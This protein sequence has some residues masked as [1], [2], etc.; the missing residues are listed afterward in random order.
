M[1]PQNNNNGQNGPMDPMVNGNQMPFNSPN[2]AYE[3]YNDNATKPAAPKK[4]QH[5]API[6][7]INTNGMVSGQK[8]VDEVWKKLGVSFGII[9]AA[10][11]VGVVVC[12]FSLTHVMRENTRLTAE[13]QR[14]DDDFKRIYDVL[15]VSDYGSAL[16]LIQGREMLT[17]PDI[18]NLNDILLKKYGADYQVD[19]GADASNFVVKTGAYKIISIDIKNKE[20][21]LLRIMLYSRN[22]DNVWHLAEIDKEDKAACTKLTDEDVKALR[23]VGICMPDKTEEIMEP[24]DVQGGEEEPE[25]KPEE[26]PAEE[27]DTSVTPE[28]K[29]GPIPEQNQK[30]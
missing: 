9:G 4:E 18:R 23:V 14:R 11:L 22:V 3:N 26:K 5:V 27:P 17:G 13:V 29:P 20:N 24:E 6:N 21:K 25:E 10:C 12:V 16:G 8:V 30:K 15:G 28:V 7:V 19:F 1:N 2:I